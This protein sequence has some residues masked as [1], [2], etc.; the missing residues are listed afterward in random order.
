MELINQA[1]KID[2][3]NVSSLFVKVRVLIS[4]NKKSEAKTFFIE[5]KFQ[6]ALN[7]KGGCLNFV[8]RYK[9]AIESYDE[10]IKINSNEAEFYYNKGIVLLNI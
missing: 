1:I 7:N 5:S 2:P 8:G 4:L 10:A 6:F 9:E 3:S